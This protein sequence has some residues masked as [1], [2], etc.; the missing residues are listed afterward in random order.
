MTDPRPVDRPLV[1]RRAPTPS[2]LEELG[3]LDRES[4]IGRAA[5]QVGIPTAVVVIATW[6]AALLKID[7]DPGAGRDMPANVVA[8]WIAVVTVALAWRMN[9]GGR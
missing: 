5:T 9:R 6:F 4:R 8:A 2:E 1:A 7:L 3:A